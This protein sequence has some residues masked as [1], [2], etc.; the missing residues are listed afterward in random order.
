MTIINYELDNKSPPKLTAVQEKNLAALTDETINYSDITELDKTFW[1]TA[2]IVE[3]D[4]TKPVT[5]R[6][7]KSV[8]NHFKQGNKKGYQSRMNAVLES[9]VQANQE[10]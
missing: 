2:T 10:Q 7:K 5:L 6:V 3:P 9:Y 8:L 4:T 1:Q